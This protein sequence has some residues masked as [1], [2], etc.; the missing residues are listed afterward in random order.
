[1]SGDRVRVRAPARGALIYRGDVLDA[2]RAMPAES[3]QCVVTSPPYWGLR[4]YGVPATAW[5]EVRHQPIAD[6]PEVAIPA[7]ECALGLEDDACAYVAHLVLIMREA[8]RVLRADGT[9]WFNL[10]DS[11]AGIGTR[12]NQGLTRSSGGAAGVLSRMGRTD[13]HSREKGRPD[14]SRSVGQ[15]LKKS[16]LTLVPTR[17]AMACQADGWYVRSEIVWYKQAGMPESIRNRPTASHE[18]IWLLTKSDRYYYDVDA[19]RE[20]HHWLGSAGN[21]NYRTWAA[22]GR[23]KAG[24]GNVPNPLGRQMRN[25]WILPP[26]P[27]PSAHFATFPRSL[28]ERAIKAGSSEHGAC[29]QCGAPWAR[30][31]EV[32]RA[33]SRSTHTKYTMLPGGTPPGTIKKARPCSSRPRT[34]A[35]EPTCGCGTDARVPCVVLDP[36]AGSG[37]TLEVALKHGRRAWGIE[38]SRDYVR[39]FTIPTVRAAARGA[40]DPRAN[41]ADPA[42]KK[43]ASNVRGRIPGKR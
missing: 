36:F 22:D 37:R 26:D 32:E 19:V 9:V 20:T 42:P 40:F 13:L 3:V 6:L 2:L 35:W 29:A 24:Q 14:A 38:L 7:Q 1:V 17:F 23:V 8:W 43:T 10:G 21:R 39:D 5:P 18:K 34:I 27:F 30:V 33:G 11:Y 28:P 15:G 41:A 4:D 12:R 16:D 25:V 31:R